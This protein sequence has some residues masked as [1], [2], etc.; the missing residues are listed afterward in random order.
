MLEQYLSSEIYT[1]VLTL[2][3]LVKHL[4]AA[5]VLKHASWLVLILQVPA[6]LSGSQPSLKKCGYFHIFNGNYL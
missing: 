1:Q 3:P 4:A 6:F 5:E 2:S